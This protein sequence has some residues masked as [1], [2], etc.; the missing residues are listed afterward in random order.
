MERSRGFLGDLGPEANT[1]MLQTCDAHQTPEEDIVPVVDHVA[2]TSS[3][4]GCK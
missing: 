2:E 1:W 3:Q 4:R